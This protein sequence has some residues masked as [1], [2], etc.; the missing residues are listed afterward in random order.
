MRHK[1]QHRELRFQCNCGAAFAFTSQLHTHSVVHHRHAAHHCVYPK[2]GRSFK[3]KGDLKR[4]ALEHTTKPHECPDCDYKNADRRNLESH[5]LFIQ[6]LRA[7]YVLSVV[8]V[9]NT[10]HSCEGTNLNVQA[11]GAVTL[12][13]I[14]TI[15]IVHGI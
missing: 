1:Y 6:T 3:N 14:K 4:H 2:C 5:D 13:I 10:T 15:T 12:R 7:M 11:S 9:L 8:R